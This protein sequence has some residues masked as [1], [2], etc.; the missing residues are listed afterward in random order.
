MEQQ[1]H[2]YEYYK[3]ETKRCFLCNEWIE[4]KIKRQ[5]IFK[6][7]YYYHLD[8]YCQIK[9]DYMRSLQTSLILFSTP[10]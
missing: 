9:K 1:N 3:E 10:N 5:R 4:G 8:C 2:E 6:T 7:I